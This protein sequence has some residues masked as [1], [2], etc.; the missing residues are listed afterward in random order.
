MTEVLISKLRRFHNEFGVFECKK[1]A[2]KNSGEDIRQVA[3]HRMVCGLF[4]Y[5][6]R[7]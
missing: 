2:R 5:S 1:R 3:H 6:H 7:I 4:G